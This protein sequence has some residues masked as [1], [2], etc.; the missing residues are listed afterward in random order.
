MRRVDSQNG[1]GASSLYV[2]L[3]KPPSALSLTVR[4]L[5][6]RVLEGAIRVPP[7]QRPLRW[8]ADDVVKL[9]DSILKGYPIGSLLFWKRPFPADSAL[10]IG[11]ATLSVPTVPDGWFIVDGQ[12]RTTALAAT[13]LDLD[14]RGDPRWDVRF[15]PQ[16]NTFRT[17]SWSVEDERRH[18]PLKTLGDLR[19]LGRWFPECNLSDGE[20]NRVEEVQQRLL[21]YE[22]PCYLVETDDVDAL[23][24]VFAR[25]NSTGVRMRADEVFQALLG[26]GADASGERRRSLDLGA[27]Q[28][29]ADLDG[30]GEPPRTEVLKAILAMSGLDPSKR[31]EDLG[32]DASARLVGAADAAEAIQRLVAFL[33][34]PSDAAEPGAGIPAYAF[35]P[36][37][38]VF[39]ILARWFHIYPEPDAATRRELAHWLW[40]GVAT[41][42]HQR[43]AVSAMRF[44]VREIREEDSAGSLARLLEAVGE[45]EAREW[46]LDPFHAIHAASRVELLALLSRQPRDQLGPVSWRAL[47][48]SGERVAR[49]IFRVDQFRDEPLRRL[50]RTAANRVLLDSR[51]SNLRTTLRTWSWEKDREALESHLIDEAGRIEL[52]QANAETFL[53]R[54][55]SRIRTLVS[56]FVQLR[57]GAGL[58]RILPVDAYYADSDPRLGS[59][60]SI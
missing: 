10:S 60:G 1:G 5:L 47:I 31:L 49:E 39:V 54:R 58:P 9:F 16:S 44:Q 27:L 57:A 30:F 26:A 18:V 4:K 43:A 21:D 56:S 28:R 2:P 6:T 51:H 3:P 17:G 29:A 7:F 50:A 45:P 20:K 14:H 40:R 36:Y 13:L 23:R 59:E 34:A 35:I 22:L 41:G 15:D 55:A 33:Q 48:S 52:E 37:P 8:E 32:E 53:A 25:L 19:R 12:Q 24:G 38:V 46:Q 11:N 42:V